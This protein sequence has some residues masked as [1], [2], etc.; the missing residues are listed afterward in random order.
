MWERREL[1]G[2]DKTLVDHLKAAQ[3]CV[4]VAKSFYAKV[5]TGELQLNPAML[6]SVISNS[7]YLELF[8]APLRA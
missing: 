8:L 3:E 4:E 6:N 1:D 5:F 2:I 7:L